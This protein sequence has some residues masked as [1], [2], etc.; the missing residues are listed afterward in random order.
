MNTFLSKTDNRI[1]RLLKILLAACLATPLLAW[2]GVLFPYTAPKAFAFRVLVEI[3]AV[4]YLYLAL[5]YPNFRPSFFSCHCE[6]RIAGRSNP[7]DGGNISGLPRRPA[8]TGLL[9]TTAAVLIFL[10]INFLAA[11][12][13]IDF[14]T[15]FWGNLERMGGIWGLLHF[16]VWFFMLT[17]VFKMD[18]SSP[19]CKRPASLSL[20]RGEGAGAC[21]P[22]LRSGVSGRADFKNQSF[23]YKLMVFSV[24]VSVSI[25]LLAI[26]QHFFSLGDLLPQVN[27]VY[28]TL[29]NAGVLGSYLIF[30]IFL[31]GYLAITSLRAQRSNLVESE[32]N[33][34]LPRRAA[35]FERSSAPRNDKTAFIVYCLLL[36]VNCFALL[37]SGTRGAMLGLLA[38]V[39]IFCAFLFFTPLFKGGEGGFKEFKKWFLTFLVLVFI[40][41]FSLFLFRDSSFVQNNSVLSRLTHISLSNATAQSRLILWQDAWRAWQARPLLGFGPANFEAAV[42][43]FLSP[44]LI[45]FEAYAF[46]RAHNFIFDYGAT[47]GWLGLISYLALFGAAGWALIKNLLP[48]PFDSAQGKL[49]SK[50]D[51]AADP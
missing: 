2:S 9:A 50:A 42:G 19:L 6:T 49:E 22:S 47:T 24:A 21:P 10:A 8:L 29:G 12:F 5:K 36:T 27:R 7:V 51:I 45:G 26:G 15:S 23:C 1:F 28:S 35:S 38:G 37:L 14:Y 33:T 41:F 39:I 46:D 32:L 4:F 34:G 3:A 30:N 16:V 48:E 31:A 44:R 40:L 17:S 20:Q 43:P 18:F 25:S 11:L 13:G